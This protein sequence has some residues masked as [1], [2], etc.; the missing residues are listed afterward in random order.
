VL[1]RQQE[2]DQMAVV[3]GRQRLLDLG[4]EAEAFPTGASSSLARSSTTRT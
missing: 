2:V 4:A 1:A 3:I